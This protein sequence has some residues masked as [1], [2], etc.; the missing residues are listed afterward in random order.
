MVHFF[1]LKH[2]YLTVVIVF[3][4]VLVLGLA[5]LGSSVNP[6]PKNLPVV[7]V[8]Q[9]AGAKTPDGQTADFGKLIAEKLTAANVPGG[10]K[11]PLAWTTAASETE[12]M[13]L[14]DHEEAYAALVIPA[15][16]SA[17][18]SSLLSSE[19]H[20]AGMKLY[21]NQGMNYSGSTMANQVLTAMLNGA[22]GQLREQMLGV[23]TQAGGM[24][25][26][27]QTQ[28]LA[29]P[30]DIQTTNV[31][32]VGTNSSNGN[33][34][35]V[36]TQL[37][38]FGAMV[39]TMMLFITANKAT[40]NGSRRHRLGI[41]LSQVLMGAVATGIAALSI[42]LIAGQ[43]FGLR[44]PDYSSIGLYLFFA[45]FMFFL[46]QTT[47]VSWLGFAGV[48]LFVLVFFFGAPIL[49]L[50]SELLPSFSH[51]YLYSWLPL[52]FSAE[53]LRDL[54]YFEG[55]HNLGSP[56]L[57]LAIIGIAGLALTL[58]SVFKKPKAVLQSSSAEGA[59]LTASSNQR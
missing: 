16:F 8:Q 52:R 51:D 49:T 19:P 50:P 55:H 45:G 14:L 43:W 27:A 29:M 3:V 2:P 53:G 44:I 22:S 15:D 33:A 39:A 56:S 18:L 26:V 17:K 46:L 57:K 20:A 23:A 21:I 41:R 24:L 5:Q 1:R 28:A 58:L 32:A 6:V 10:G 36:L 42:L 25:T 38:W 11:S 4:V 59:T 13:E 35:V 30:I 12:A 37:V 7:L 31:N 34:P 54:F 9:D 48:P 47:V 40:Q